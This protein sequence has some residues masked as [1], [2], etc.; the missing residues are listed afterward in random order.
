MQVTI[1]YG[2]NTINLTL[3]DQSSYDEFQCLPAG[4][5]ATE[6]SFLT[7]IEV[8]E[9]ELFP[10]CEADLL[11][12]N[13][14]YRPTPTAQILSWLKNNGRL[15][16]DAK[17]LVATGCHQPPTAEQMHVILGNLH[18]QLHRRVIVHDARNREI[19]V[20]VGDE[21]D[22]QPVCLNRHFNDA[23]RPVLIGSVE[24]HYFAGFTGGRKS[25]F[26]GLC[27]F[28]TT[29][30]NH[31]LAVSFDAAPMRLK[32]NPVAEG[33]DNLMD[34]IAGRP[35]FGIQIVSTAEI[36][37]Q[38]VMCGELKD[39]FKRACT[40]SRRIFGNEVDRQYDLILAEVLPPLDSNLYQLQKSL[41][42][43]QA[44][45]RDGGAIILF[46]P[47]REGIGSQD[48]YRLAERWKTEGAAKLKDAFGVHKLFRVDK[49]GRRLDVFLYSMLD[50][51]VAEYVFYNSIRDPQRIVNRMADKKRQMSIALVHDAGHTVLTVQ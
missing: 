29:A 16:P 41:E 20:R 51:G 33:L 7:D 35:L 23:R 12:V 40:Q 43:C 44:A 32:S 21:V 2:T 38:A 30:R 34:L 26:P 24:P 31:G 6:Q 36:G 39:A 37:L 48:F 3:P 27:D 46:S 9:R 11:V 10:I 42:N 49:I 15:N 13:D 22:G 18:D 4:E 17:I 47:C 5:T 8:A 14:A 19:M 28:E 50:E 1:R 45:V 25:V